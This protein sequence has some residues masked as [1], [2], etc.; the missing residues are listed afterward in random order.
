MKPS[1]KSKREI[2]TF[3]HR[4]KLREVITSTCSVKGYKKFFKKKENDI[5]HK[6]AS[7]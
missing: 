6:L 1:F 4:H 2:K 7:I 5:A 3:S